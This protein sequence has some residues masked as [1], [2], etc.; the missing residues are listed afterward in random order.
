[1]TTTRNEYA[2]RGESHRSALAR[3]E[4]LGFRNIRVVKVLGTTDRV[5]KVMA[6]GKAVRK[7]QKVPVTASM[8]LEVSDGRLKRLAGLFAESRISG[9]L[10]QQS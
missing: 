1:M 3:L 7:M 2:L 9:Q 6:N 10:P 4:E 8:V 5:V